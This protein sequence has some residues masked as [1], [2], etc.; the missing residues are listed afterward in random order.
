MKEYTLGKVYIWKKESLLIQAAEE[1]GLNHS[2]VGTRVNS[3]SKK[4]EHWKYVDEKNIPYEKVVEYSN[5]AIKKKCLIDGIEYESIKSASDTLK[6]PPT[7]LRRR[8]LSDKFPNYS[9]VE[10]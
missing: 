9:Y 4:F 8:L 2:T 1:L 5:G 3:D 10:K 7:T 6:I